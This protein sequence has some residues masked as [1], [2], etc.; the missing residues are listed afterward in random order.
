VLLQ[1]RGFDIVAQGLALGDG[2]EGRPARVRLDS[3]RVLTGQPVGE[4]ALQVTM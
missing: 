4:Q 1:G 2:I 3:G